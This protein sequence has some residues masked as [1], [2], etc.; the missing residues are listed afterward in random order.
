MPMV[1]GE[2]GESGRVGSRRMQS[3]IC[4]GGVW[5]SPGEA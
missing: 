1:F 2:N 3:T 5:V 4:L